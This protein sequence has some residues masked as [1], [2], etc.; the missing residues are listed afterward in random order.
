MPKG[1]KLEKSVNISITENELITIEIALSMY[2]AIMQ[3]KGK[4]SDMTCADAITNKL[5]LADIV[6][7]EQSVNVNIG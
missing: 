2:A 1:V 5:I 7:A 6:S 4:L 3:R